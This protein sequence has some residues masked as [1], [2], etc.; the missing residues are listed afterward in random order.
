MLKR[1][2]VSTLVF[3]LVW[4]YVWGLHRYDV[5]NWIVSGGQRVGLEVENISGHILWTEDGPFFGE[6][7]RVRIA[8]WLARNGG[9]HAAVW[10]SFLSA[11]AAYGLCARAY[12]WRVLGYRGP[13][14]CGVCGYGL[15]GLREPRCPECGRAI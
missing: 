13:T 7:L 3:G 14:R 8:N 4:L 5:E 15:S 6:G 2:L 1:L 9:L 10:C 11:A 12:R